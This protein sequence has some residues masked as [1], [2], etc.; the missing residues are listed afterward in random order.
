MR[1]QFKKFMNYFFEL[2]KLHFVKYLT[3]GIFMTITTTLIMW[4]FVDYIG[5]LASIVNIPL[6][7]FFFL[8]KYPIYNSLNMLHKG[9]N[10]FMKYL[11]AG[12]SFFIIALIASTYVMWL[13]V[14]YLNLPKISINIININI[15]PVIYVN[16]LWIIFEFISR[17]YFFK[18]FKVFSHKEKS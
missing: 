16:I 13:L 11:I 3:V 1:I 2:M 17:F 10:M 12:S 8:I 14:D 9:K 7:I 15:T 6:R 4:F 5:I 18:F